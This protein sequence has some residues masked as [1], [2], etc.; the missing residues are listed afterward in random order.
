MRLAAGQKSITPGGAGGRN[1][2]TF[3][4]QIHLPWVLFVAYERII[5]T[6]SVKLRVSKL[7][8]V[9]PKIL[10]KILPKR[11]PKILLKVLPKVLPKIL[12][13]EAELELTQHQI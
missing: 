12:P 10:P 7:G 8:L 1:K 6:H 2:V 13:K 4:F 5:F 9:L 11:L 3:C